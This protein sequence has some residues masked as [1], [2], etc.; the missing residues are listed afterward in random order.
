MNDPS[1]L[2]PLPTKPFKRMSL[3]KAIISLMVSRIEVT[4][5]QH[6]AGITAIEA[7]EASQFERQ[8][9]SISD[10]PEV[11]KQLRDIAI[12]AA[13]LGI[14]RPDQFSD[15]FRIGLLARSWGITARD[16]NTLR[17]MFSKGLVPR[18]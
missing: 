4:I 1:D 9:K 6:R 5:A 10:S 16:I 17:Q 15:G 7:V 12:A 18:D 2:T 8:L 3:P 11:R 14:T 13:Q